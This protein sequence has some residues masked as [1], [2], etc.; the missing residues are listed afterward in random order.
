M[1]MTTMPYPPCLWMDIER[2]S[3][4]MM[5]IGS[6]SQSWSACGMGAFTLKGA[7]LPREKDRPLERVLGAR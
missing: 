2:I 7:P 4:W 5:W 3:H 6:S 1:P